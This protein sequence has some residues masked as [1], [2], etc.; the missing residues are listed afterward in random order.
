MAA[1]LDTKSLTN[2]SCIHFLFHVYSMDK[3]PHPRPIVKT[4]RAPEP[5]GQP[6]APSRHPTPREQR[7]STTRR[8]SPIAQQRQPDAIPPAPSTGKTHSPNRLSL[9]L[10]T[11]MDSLPQLKDTRRSL[12][13]GTSMDSLPQLKDTRRSRPLGTSMDSLNAP[14][15][16]NPRVRTFTPRNQRGEVKTASVRRSNTPLKSNSPSPI[17]IEGDTV[18]IKPKTPLKSNSPSPSIEGGIK[19]DEVRSSNTPLKS[20]SPSPSIEDG[21]KDD[22]GRRYD[23]GKYS[24]KLTDKE[25]K[26]LKKIKDTVKF[27][28]T[29]LKIRRFS[30]NIELVKEAHMMLNMCRVNIKNILALNKDG[31]LRTDNTVDEDGDPVSIVDEVK[32]KLYHSIDIYDEVRSKHGWFGFGGTRKRKK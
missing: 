32:D 8:A 14:N 13:L 20:N 19:D 12:P 17:F 26:T 25:I 27:M 4:R 30:T 18:G 10:G 3:R 15:K 2:P 6:P 29:D 1:S 7:V 16:D 23:I 24:V 11:S 28:L 9:P 21:I 22:E 5:Q 31:K